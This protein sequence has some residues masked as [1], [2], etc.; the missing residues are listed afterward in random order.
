M[1]C[2]NKTPWV[3]RLILI[4]VVAAVGVVNIAKDC[5]E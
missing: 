2:G 3:L 4:L 5:Q 1:C